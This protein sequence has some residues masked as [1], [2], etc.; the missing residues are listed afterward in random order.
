[1]NKSTILAI[2][3]NTGRLT[4][5]VESF[6]QQFYSLTADAEETAID[7]FLQSPVDAVVFGHDLGDTVKN[8]LT[9][10]FSSQQSDT[11]FVNDNIAANMTETIT[12]A[13]SS[14]QKENKPVFSFKDDALKNAGLHIEIQ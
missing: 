9:K 5:L 3:N 1:M 8:R 10:I 6:G 14:K 7:R 12:H 13:I 11:V 2:S 4:A